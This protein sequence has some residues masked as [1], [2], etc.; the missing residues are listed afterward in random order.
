MIPPR[1][2]PLH[3]WSHRILLVLIIGGSFMGI[4]TTVMSALAVS[5]WTA[6]AYGGLILATLFYGYGLFVGLRLA[7]LPNDIRHVVIFY[8]LQVPF[9][10]SPFFL[11]R[12]MAGA[13]ADV[14]YFPSG[15]AANY[16]FGSSWEVG[17]LE[18]VPWGF[19][20]NLFAVGILCAL[21]V[22]KAS[23]PAAP[24]R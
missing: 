2:R 8:L 21:F 9:F 22:L 11:F 15:F 18:N 24:V 5:E 19:G 14:A 3:V 13:D 10:S 4:S 6:S 17:V 12:F 7:E 1:P 20:I 16:R 23:T